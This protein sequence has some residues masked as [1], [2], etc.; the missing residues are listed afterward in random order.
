MTG[1][2]THGRMGSYS[3]AIALAQQSGQPASVAL[4]RRY[5]TRGG[6][7]VNIEQ[8]LTDQLGL[9]VRAGEADG[10]KE[11]YEFADIDQTVAAGLV[12]GGRC[13]EKAGRQGGARLCDQRRFPRRTKPIRTPAGPAS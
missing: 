2:L 10:S 1:F 13:V 11:A 9:F 5:Q 6:V 7:S 3:D 12:A 4:V 8:S